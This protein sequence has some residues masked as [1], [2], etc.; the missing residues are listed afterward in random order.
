[1]HG[2]VPRGFD[3][4]IADIQM[5]LL[6]RIEHMDMK[7]K[8]LQ[9]RAHPWLRTDKTSKRAI[10]GKA[11]MQALKTERSLVKKDKD[12][13]ETLLNWIDNLEW[14]G[15]GEVS[16][17]ELAIDF[18]ATTET[19]LCRD[20][21]ASITDR[22]RKFR[23]K[24]QKLN[25]ICKKINVPSVISGQ[26]KSR[27]HSLRSVGGPAVIGYERRPKF[28]SHATRKV[29]EEQIIKAIPR[30]RAWGKD[31]CPEYRNAQQKNENP[32]KRRRTGS[33]LGG[34]VK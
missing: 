7:T 15:T 26:D 30:T 25:K 28:R 4:K 9:E 34:T 33:T 13:F 23:A 5:Q 32:T 24:I 19:R 16:C 1:M 10:E 12:E 6:K 21:E 20:K 18:E 31:I 14:Y 2:I 29:L 22:A 17:V 3:V 11:I 27:V 8:P